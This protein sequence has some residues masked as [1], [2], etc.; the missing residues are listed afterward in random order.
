MSIVPL[1]RTEPAAGT[2][3]RWGGAV[4][5]R[6]GRG[7]RATGLPAWQTLPCATL[8]TSIYS[9]FCWG[10]REWEIRAILLLVLYR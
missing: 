3:E 10:G 1:V 4:G 9:V 6:A 5:A 8:L 7:A 2:G